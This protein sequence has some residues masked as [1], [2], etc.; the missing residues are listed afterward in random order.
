M[1]T[2][3][4]EVG[5][6]GN[7]DTRHWFTDMDDAFTYYF[8]LAELYGSASLLGMDECGK[9]TPLVSATV[10]NRVSRS[11]SHCS[12]S[13]QGSG[14]LNSGPRGGQGGRGCFTITIV[15]DVLILIFSSAL[16]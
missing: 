1:R 3:R 8:W 13:S 5:V 6:V 16:Y 11:A 10:F 14:G 2:I 4:F 7:R 9:I 15:C 12:V